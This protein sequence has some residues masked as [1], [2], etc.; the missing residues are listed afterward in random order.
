MTRAIGVVALAAVLAVSTAVV[1]SA[2]VSSAAVSSAVEAKPSGDSS[3]D[4]DGGSA[5][6]PGAMPSDLTAPNA[7]QAQM[8]AERIGNPVEDLSQR[9]PTV[10]VWALPDGTWSS[11]M[12]SAP[13]WVR[14]G[15]GDGT[16]RSDWARSD[17]TLERR[18]DGSVAPVAQ[19][20]GIVLAG[21]G[22]AT[23]LLSE[24]DP[25]TGVSLRVLWDGSRLPRPVL[26][27]GRATYKNVYP[28]VDLVIDIL[29][30][31]FEEYFVVRTRAALRAAPDLHLDVAV[32]GA[33]LVD[34]GNG[35]FNVVAPDGTVVGHSPGA[36]AWDAITDQVSANPV[37]EEWSGVPRARVGLPWSV[38]IGGVQL[39]R[40]ATIAS[41]TGSVPVAAT[42][43]DLGNRT[44]VSLAA[45][46]EW[47]DDPGTTFPIVIDPSLGGPYW[48]T[49]VESGYTTDWSLR[50]YLLIGTYTGL[51]A[52]RTFMTWNT[53]S[54]VGKDITSARLNIYMYWSSQCN[55]RSWYVYTANPVTSY[56]RWETQPTIYGYAVTGSTL[57]TGHTSC[58][59]V[60]NAYVDITDH[61]KYWSHLSGGY[62]GLAIV[63]GSESDITYWKRFYSSNASSHQPSI[64]YTYNTEPNVPSG[65]TVDD[66]ALT[67]DR[68]S[69]VTRPEVSAV[70]TDPDG[71]EVR[72]LFTILQG[73]VVIIDSLPGTVVA[74]GQV[75]SAT[76]PYGLSSNAAYTIEVRATDTRLIG[77]AVSPTYTFTGPEGSVREIP[78]GDDDETGV[79]S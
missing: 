27:G 7:Y 18:A 4:S 17:Q 36:L 10:S 64:S 45:D 11:T 40:M 29:P 23:V 12:S 28:G 41:E 77:D 74:S 46:A 52:H 38:P 26:D 73:G 13:Q 48:D 43:E 69:S 57:T 68:T 75:S 55:P 20:N 39:E 22:P 1:S 65:V 32:E 58:P 56:I 63:S 79:A 31:G 19:V 25:E 49:Y 33:D 24:T 62:R 59:A 8:L 67:E 21:G 78:A 44:R 37:M 70:V 53:T 2:A 60:Q 30:E 34:D 9:T 50:T 76:L 71:G 51:G 14:T 72:A 42:L 54:L 16:S 61:A 5:A 47:V 66:L 35:G 3:G 6:P 15:E